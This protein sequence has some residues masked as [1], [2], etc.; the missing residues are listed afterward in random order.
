MDLHI[1]GTA[2]HVGDRVHWASFPDGEEMK[3]AA[4]AL[5]YHSDGKRAGMVKL[6]HKDGTLTGWYNLDE[7]SIE[8]AA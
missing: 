4:L 7:R 8:R 2:Y 5:L 6:L 1:N 3:I